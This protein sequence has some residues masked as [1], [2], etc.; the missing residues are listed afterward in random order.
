MRGPKV[1]PRNSFVFYNHQQKGKAYLDALLSNGFNHLDASWYRDLSMVFTDSDILGKK[2]ILA[3]YKQYGN[4][5]TFVIPH[6]ARPNIV[7][8]VS[9]GWEHT[10][11][12]F[13]VTKYHAEVMRTY[14]IDKPIHPVGWSLCPIKP[15]KPRKTPRN[16]LFA[17]IHPRCSK[18]DQD[19]N[20]ATF[21]RLEKLAKSDDI[22]LTVRFIKSLEQSGLQKIEHPN[23]RYTVGYMNQ[24][25]KQIDEADVVVGHQTFPWLA[26]ARG[27]PT[28]MM[29]E[30]DLI[31]HIEPRGTQ[32]QFARHWKD[33]VDL[34]AYPLDILCYDDTLK[35]LNTAIKRNC[36]VEDWRKR[37]IGTPF[38]KDRFI[39]AIQK[40]L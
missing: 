30:R 3:K 4:K 29:A 16:V 19:V 13:C 1:A 37:M 26:V 21:K 15:Y 12:Y 20:L 27:V 33:Y 8:D 11:A 9:P 31:T 5:C 14:G 23:I 6:T 38:R 24:A 35:L 36:A 18:I 2:H 10:T 39:A 7:N 22:V 28:L 34:I 25:Y 32:P 17:P 40:Y